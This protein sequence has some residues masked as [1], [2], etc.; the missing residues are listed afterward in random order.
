MLSGNGGQPCAAGRYQ[1]T[2]RRR[3]IFTTCILLPWQ[4]NALAGNPGRVLL[5][6]LR[7]SERYKRPFQYYQPQFSSLYG[8]QTRGNS[9]YNGL[10]LTL[11]HAM[12]AGL[13]FDFNYTFSKAIDVGSNAERVN[14]FESGGIAY[15]SQVINAFSPNLWRAV[16]D[17]DTTHQL[18]AN[19]IWDVP[20]GRQPPLGRGIK[21]RRQRC[22]WWL[23]VER[24]VPLDQR[25][26]VLGSRRKRVG[27]RLRTRRNFFC[28]GSETEDRRLPRS[29]RRSERLPERD[30]SDLHLLS[31]EMGLTP[32]SV[33]PTLARP[34]S[35]TTSGDRDT[36][37]ST[38]DWPN[39]GM[40]AK[41]NCSSFRGKCLT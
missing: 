10:Q 5:P 37:A 14:G 21:R 20:F 31:R 13:Q 28:T 40:S 26:P 6:S 19:W 24:P 30:Q 8:W 18:N 15:N 17:F 3:R 38:V 4:R 11:R 25:L 16:S 35:A 7:R 39:P 29:G 36:L 34:G 12:A 41:T 1:Q 27:H 22:I 9:N 2:R 32:T 33:Q 23:D